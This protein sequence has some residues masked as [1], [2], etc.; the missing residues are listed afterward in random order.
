[1]SIEQTDKID[2]ISLRKETNSVILTISDHLDWSYTDN[3]LEKLQDK[4]N[5][6]LSFCESGEIYESYPQA[7]D[8][9]IVIEVKGKYPLN[10]KG[11]KFYEQAREVIQKVGLD[12]RFILVKEEPNTL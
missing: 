3:H 11:E 4:L 5:T 1:M 7:K 8:K 10:N 9:K 12:L 6:Y 2:F